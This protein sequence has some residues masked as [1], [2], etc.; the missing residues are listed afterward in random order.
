MKKSMSVIRRIA[1]AGRYKLIKHNL[2]LLLML[3]LVGAVP[4]TAQQTK[5]FIALHQFNG[6]IKNGVADGANPEGAL[7]LDADGNL[8]GTTFAGGIGEGT[9]FKIDATGKESV[10]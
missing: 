7:L 6:Q 5:H 10:L 9:V 8:F 3:T 4:S 1:A 2:A